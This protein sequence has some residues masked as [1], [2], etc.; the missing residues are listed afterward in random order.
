[1]P[2]THV[3][4]ECYEVLRKAVVEGGGCARA[5]R[6]RTLLMLKGMAAWMKCT[7]EISWRSPVPV[8]SRN[9]SPLPPG[10]E[11]NLVEIM[12]TMVLANAMEGIA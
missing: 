6:G 8:A 5:L 1:M 11:Q 4:V 2:D 9:E 3:L 7:G 12:A 10:S